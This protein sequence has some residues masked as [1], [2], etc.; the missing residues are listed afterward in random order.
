M[1]IQITEQEITLL[2]FNGCHNT[3]KPFQTQ[4]NIIIT[5]PYNKSHDAIKDIEEHNDNTP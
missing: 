1:V 2:I 5:N 3:T 4:V